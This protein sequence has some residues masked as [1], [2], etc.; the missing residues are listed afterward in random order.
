MFSVN[1][2]TMEIKMH[3]GDTGSF[4]IHAERGSG[5]AWTYTAAYFPHSTHPSSESG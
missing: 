3:A 5:D 1:L 4:K 2:E